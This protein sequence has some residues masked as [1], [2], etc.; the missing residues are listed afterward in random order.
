MQ[1]KDYILIPI[2]LTV[3]L[4]LIVGL[5][6]GVQYLVNIFLDFKFTTINGPIF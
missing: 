5:M 1:K 4:S 6:L 2:F 3:V